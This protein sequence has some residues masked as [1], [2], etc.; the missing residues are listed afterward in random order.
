MAIAEGAHPKTIQA[1]MGHASVQVTL[2]RYGHLF[3]E[4]DQQVA[5]GLDHTFRAALRVVEGGSDDRSRDTA[6]TQMTRARHENGGSGG[7][8]RSRAD[9]PETGPDQRE[10]LEAA[11][12]IEPVYRALQALA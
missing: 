11:T 2:D 12:G 1:R 9:K 5:E 4:L 6:R 10:H 3:P 8:Q 7:L